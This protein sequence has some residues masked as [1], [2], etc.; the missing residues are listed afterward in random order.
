MPAA[1]GEE[2]SPHLGDPSLLAFVGANYTK[3]CHSKQG[4][5]KKKRISC[6]SPA[7]DILIDFR[8]LSFGGGFFC[9]NFCPSGIPPEGLFLSTKTTKEV[10]P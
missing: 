5:A 10:R 4:G 6:G 9:T 8:P 7:S 3:S 2:L 1:Q